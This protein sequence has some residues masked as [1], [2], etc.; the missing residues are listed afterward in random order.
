MGMVPGREFCFLLR[1]VGGMD[2]RAGPGMMRLQLGMAGFIRAVRVILMGAVIVFLMIVG[3][4][5]RFVSW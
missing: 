3:C 5:F 1:M 4:R 2:G